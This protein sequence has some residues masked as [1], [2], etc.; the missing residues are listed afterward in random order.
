[1]TTTSHIKRVDDCLC[2]PVQ[3]G[4]VYLECMADG[5]WAKQKNAS[6]CET[7]DPAQTDTVRAQKPD[8]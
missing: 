3:H 8:W 4:M 5:Q 7:N 2:I 1:M 6:E